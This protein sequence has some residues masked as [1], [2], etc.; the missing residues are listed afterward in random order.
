MTPQIS[1][2]PFDK[3]IVSE[4]RSIEDP[5][6]GL[7]DEPLEHLVSRFQNLEYDP[8]PRQSKLTRAQF[9]V[10]PQPGYGKSH[11]IGRLFKEFNGKATLV[12]IRPFEDSS[13]CW[14]T[15]L[16]NTVQELDFPDRFGVDNSSSNLPTQLEA[17]AHGVLIHLITDAIEGGL[18]VT[19]NK[20]DVIA[21]LAKSSVSRFRKDQKWL[22]WIRKGMNG[23][24]KR[25]KRQLDIHNITLNAS[26]LSWIRVLLNYTY[27]PLS[28]EL[29]EACKDWLLG[30]CIDPV[31]AKH[32]GIRTKDIP[33]PDMQL[34]EINE[35]CKHR[36]MDLCRLAGFF[37]PFVYCF[38]QTENFVKDSLLAKSFG[39]VVQVLVDVCPNQMTVV[40]ANQAAWTKGILPCLEEAHQNRFSSP[41]D[42]KGLNKNQGMILIEQRLKGMG[43]ERKNRR[44]FSESHW[45]DQLFETS[46]ELGIRDFL[47]ECA[48]RWGKEG[49]LKQSLQD[50]YQK[51]IKAL[52]KQSRSLVFDWNTFYW[53]IHEVAEGLAGISIQKVETQKGY[54]ILSWQLKDR[55]ILFGF[56]TGKNSSRWQAIAR[57]AERHH[58]VQKKTK[59]VL[60]RTPD[61][62]AIPQPSWEKI[63][64]QIEIAKR[65]YLHIIHLET[66]AMVEIYSAHNLFRDAVEGNIPYDSE[67]VSAFI[68]QKLQKFWKII[69]KPLPGASAK[70]KVKKSSKINAAQI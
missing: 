54:F 34:E 44:K 36:I 6:K 17:F 8:K 50:C 55:H 16:L 42:L 62:A 3:D 70:S 26:Y 28:D 60:F 27:F 41:L 9:V 21:S 49:D 65:H 53:L 33:L 14:R 67:E 68:R 45:L 39:L 63:A 58:T 31:E 25:F 13:A 29:K 43:Q 4:P 2:N 35:L 32:L 48:K 52:K 51:K 10:S 47:R 61:L 18:F 69:L 15:I 30:G 12:Y 56:E 40:T 59:S 46:G 7:N 19:D 38:D 22:E 11:L 37:R 57:E 24:S 5:V 20:K 66:S 1:N 64:P 23:L